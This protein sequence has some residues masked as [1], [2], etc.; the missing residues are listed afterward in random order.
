MID[1]CGRLLSELAAPAYLKLLPPGTPPLLDL[2]EFLTLL[3]TPLC[4][5]KRGGIPDSS[6]AAVWFIKWWREEGGL[7]SASAPALPDYSAASGLETFRRGWGFDLEWSVDAAQAS[8][9]DETAIQMKM[10]EC[11]DA[12]EVAAEEEERDGGSISSTQEKKR[13]KEQQKTKQRARSRARLAAR[14][15]A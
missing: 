9:Y 1:A 3:A 12:F 10:E 5:L 6:R 13:L 2:H 14:K 11:I 15:G 4:M 7:A 8:R